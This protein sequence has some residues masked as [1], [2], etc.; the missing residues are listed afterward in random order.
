M[1]VL[2]KQSL[3]KQSVGERRKR[4]LDLE[5][6]QLGVFLAYPS[7]KGYSGVCKL[8]LGRGRHLSRLDEERVDATE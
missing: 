2:Q 3:I 8:G 1:V 5:S 7:V 6:I 4:Y